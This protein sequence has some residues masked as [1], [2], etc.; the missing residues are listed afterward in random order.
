MTTY[1]DDLGNTFELPKLTIALAEEMDGVPNKG[2]FKETAKAMYEFVKKVLPGDYLKAELDGSKLDSIDIVKLR[3]I[4]D[5]INTAYT[6]AL[7]DGRVQ[8][9]NEQMENIAPMLDTLSKAMELN[10]QASSR[11]GFS[12]VK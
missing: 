4:Y 7:E 8:S 12:R 3:N 6:S 9:M 1:S 5:G 2:G 11:Q 10:R